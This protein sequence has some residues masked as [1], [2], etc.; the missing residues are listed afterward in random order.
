MKT[1]E[2]GQDIKLGA[3]VLAGL[4]IFIATVFFIG[5]ENSIFSRTFTVVSIFKN[6]E[7]LKE[8]DNVWLSGVKIGTVK[9][10]RIVS[11]GKVIV[12]LLLKERQNEFIAK[13]AT[14]YIGSDGLVGNKIVVVRP[15]DAAHH[16]EDYDTINA[17]SPTDTQDLIN[18]AKDVG[19]NTRSLTNDLQVISKKVKDGEGVVGELLNDGAFAQDLRQTVSSLRTA[20]ANMNRATAELNVLVAEIQHGDGVFNKLIYDTTLA[21]TFNTAIVNVKQVSSHASKIATDLQEVAAKINSHDNA[22]GLLLADTTFA[23][24]M[25]HTLINAENA[26]GKLDENMEALQHNFLL[27]GYFRK[28]RKNENNQ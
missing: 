8:G 11:E 5:A 17:A 25:E 26:S 4:A 24:R 2:I 14:A 7:G 12:E 18:I 27:R 19:Q 9:D 1:R 3:F 22:L 21:G 6:V 16:I 23:K 15:G 20:G 13:N 28:K 10:V